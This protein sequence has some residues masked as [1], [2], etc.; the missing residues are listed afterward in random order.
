MESQ[1][2]KYS[3]TCDVSNERE[4]SENL[5]NQRFNFFLIFFGLI[6]GGASAS[7][8]PEF[9]VAILIAG[10]FIC[11]LLAVPI[12]RIQF[13]F[14]IIFNEMLPEN[15]PAK[16]A[17]RLSKEKKKKPILVNKSSRRIIG[18][19]IPFLCCCFITGFTIF[20]CWKSCLFL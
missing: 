17:D 7:S 9:S 16:V 2:K 4:F 12:F 11:W 15:H 14:D 3:C 1:E 6:L 13:K 8:K 18:Y 19:Y 20:V 5:L 10:T